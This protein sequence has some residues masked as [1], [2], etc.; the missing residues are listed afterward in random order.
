MEQREDDSE[1]I[2]RHRLAEYY[3]NTT[4]LLNYYKQRGVLMQFDGELS[5]HDL[6]E[7]LMLA[8]GERTLA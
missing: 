4:Q 5:I 6:T 8:V 2:V 7:A 1:D 3:E